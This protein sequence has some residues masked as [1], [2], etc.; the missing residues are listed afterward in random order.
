MNKKNIFWGL[1]FLG[2]GAV[3]L[4][5]ALGIGI[6]QGVAPLVATVVLAAVGIA[7]LIK[8]NFVF[9]TV[10]AALILHIWSEQIGLDE[11]N[12]WTLLFASVLVGIGL[13]AIFW[14]FK[15]SSS[16]NHKFDHFCG[17]KEN[18]SETQDDE[19]VQIMSSFGEHVR[20]VQS[21]NF[22][23]ADIKAHFS[24]LKVYFNSCTVSPEGAQINVDVNFAGLEL[25]IPK[26]WN[27]LTEVHPFL[28]GIED[29]GM[30]LAEGEVPV[31]VKFRG[32][33]SFAGVEVHRI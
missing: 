16:F 23:S 17:D 7:A 4:M 31:S 13:T 10:P 6:T 3:I 11:I 19:S 24:S 12:L 28:G 22:R 33:I 9:V 32:N 2:V 27:L 25:Y 5:Y 21:D 20:Y 1:L 15:K 18:I 26:N 14:K 29:S 8:L 30:I